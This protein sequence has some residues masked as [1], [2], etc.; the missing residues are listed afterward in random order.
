MHTICDAIPGRW[1]QREVVL[2]EYVYNAAGQQ[3]IR[4]LTQTSETLHAIHGPDGNRIAEYLYD[5]IA[6]T[7]TLLREYIWL[8]EGPVAAVEGDYFIRA[9]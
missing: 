3:V 6:Q 7:S 1:Y 4:R 9:D 8:N 5:D 2:S